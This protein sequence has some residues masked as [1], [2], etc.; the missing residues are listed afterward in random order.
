MM[1]LLLA[2]GICHEIVASYINRIEVINDQALNLN[3]LFDFITKKHYQIEGILRW[4]QVLVGNL[5]VFPV[6]RIYQYF[7]SLFCALISAFIP[8]S[9]CQ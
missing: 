5:F 3:G 9:H 7:N 2:S 6:V 4:C 1:K 8:R